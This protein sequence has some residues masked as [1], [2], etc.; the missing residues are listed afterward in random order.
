MLIT[1]KG[2]MVRTRISEIRAVGRNTMGVK[3]MD[4]R[5]ARKS[6]RRSRRSSVRKR[7]RKLR[8]L[9][10][11]IPLLAGRMC[12]CPSFIVGRARTD[13]AFR[14]DQA[15]CVIPIRSR[16]ESDVTQRLPWL[17]KA[18]ARPT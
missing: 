1:T 9:G 2:Q 3:L 16:T 14:N 4:L 7:K 18:I 6:S 15:R 11:T 10:L 17:Q 12:F 13:S 8:R 5:G